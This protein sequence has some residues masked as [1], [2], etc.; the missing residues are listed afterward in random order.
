[1]P[2]KQALLDTFA[3][4]V[5]NT[6]S[7]PVSI[8]CQQKR[9]DVFVEFKENKKMDAQEIIQSCAQKWAK[10]LSDRNW[11]Q[12]SDHK[13][14]INEEIGAEIR[15]EY[16]QSLDDAYH[17]WKK[18]NGTWFYKDGYILDPF[19]LYVDFYPIE[20]KVNRQTWNF[21]QEFSSRTMN[22]DTE[23]EDYDEDIYYKQK[24]IIYNSSRDQWYKNLL[25]LMSEDLRAIEKD[26]EDLFID[27]EDFCKLI[28][29][30][31]LNA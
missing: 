10:L 19:S 18:T 6:K 4:C 21:I 14:E 7:I 27:P 31:S 26:A 13:V 17:L 25:N 24:K 2:D 23:D 15:T 12:V 5:V 9:Y 3:N 1:M 29:K 8:I 11:Y 28:E 30:E 20:E 22:D 16:S